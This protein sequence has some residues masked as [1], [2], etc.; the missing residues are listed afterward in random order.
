MGYR[1]A[2]R[3]RV[4]TEANTRT[5]LTIS[6]YG[7]DDRVANPGD[8]L[9]TANLGDGP[10]GVR[11]E[12]LILGRDMAGLAQYVNEAAADYEANREWLAAPASRPA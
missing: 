6:R 8:L 11:V 12:L 10:T 9:L 4:A 7:T 3:V 1:P 2:A 5:S